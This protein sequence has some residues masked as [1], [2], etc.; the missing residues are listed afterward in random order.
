PLDQALTALARQ[1]GFDIIST[2]PGLAHV[3][4]KGVTGQ[5][6]PREALRRLLE[7]T[8]YRAVAVDDRSYRIVR[9]PRLVVHPRLL[10]RRTAEPASGD[11][12]I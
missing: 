6:P 9:A 12:I 8:G 11:D 4:T 5:M 3:R 7:G 10:A 2:E 1:I